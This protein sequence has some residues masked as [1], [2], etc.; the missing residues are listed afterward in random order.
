MHDHDPDLIAALADGSLDQADEA[1]ARTRIDACADCRA[2]YQGQRAVLEWLRAAPGAEMTDL[3]KAALH[4]DLW[5]G[6]REA[7]D[8]SPANPWWYRWSYVAAGLFV[9]IGLVAVIGNQVRFG[10]DTGGDML[11]VA[12]P[13]ADSASGGGEPVPLYGAQESDGQAESATTTMAAA[14]EALPYPFPDLAAEARA[15]RQSASGVDRSA[16]LPEGAADC[17]SDLGLTD[18]EVVDVLE[19]DQPYLVVMPADPARPETVTFIAFEECR[20]AFVDG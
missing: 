17:L 14:E 4:R 10:G 12:E 20:I 2:E 9:V 6:L 1:L 13:A 19:L 8:R 11:E 7:P 5:A 15:M 3:E 16:S 18:E